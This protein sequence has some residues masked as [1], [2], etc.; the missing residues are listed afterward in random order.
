MDKTSI[1]DRMKNYEA[2]TDT[3]LMPRLPVIVRLDGKKFSTFTKN[4][5][6]P[7]DD[8]FRQAM[9]NTAKFLVSKT[10]AKIAY[11]QSDEIT[12]VM[13]AENEKS[14]SI[15]FDAR[16]QK[17]C[18]TFAGMASTY[19]LMEVMK[20][21]PE[22]I[23]KFLE[24]VMKGWDGI[25]NMGNLPIFDCR[26]FA[27]PTKIEAYNAVLWREQDAT[28]NSITMVAQSHYSHKQLKGVS[29]KEKQA[30]LLEEKGIN[31]N[32]FTAAQ[33][34]GVYIRKEKYEVKLEQDKL[35]KIPEEY[36]PNNGMVIRSKIVEM[37]MPQLT[38]VGNPIEVFFNGEQPIT[39]AEMEKTKNIP[40]FLN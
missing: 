16:V 4:M 1:G 2:A 39:K 15:I 19:F 5:K 6:R 25:T 34:R 20:R 18:S 14:G 24:E 35:D 33:K 23:D 13:Y 8:D 32:N 36:K 30:M 21:W 38:K 10:D 29:G 22:K 12:L 17:I 26:I 31:W 27:V 7:F 9:V 11:T 3:R 37:D 28:K 40:L